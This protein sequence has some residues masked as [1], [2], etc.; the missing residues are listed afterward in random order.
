MEVAEVAREALD[1]EVGLT[2]AATGEEVL[3]IELIILDQLDCALL[4]LAHPEHSV[5]F[6]A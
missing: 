1:E 3:Y 5:A 2:A 6:A 4:T